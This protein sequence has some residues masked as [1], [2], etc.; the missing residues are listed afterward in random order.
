[1]RCWLLVVISLLPCRVAAATDVVVLPFVN[2]S[3]DQGLRW[4][5]E[6]FPE[7]L[8]ERLRWPRLNILGREER[9]LAYDRIGIPYTNVL[10]KASLVKVGQEL[11]ADVLVLGEYQVEERNLQ[12]TAS[13]L[14]LRRNWLSQEIKQVG[15]LEDLQAISGRLAWEILRLLESGFPLS[16]D[17]FVSRFRMI[18]NIAL[19]HY[20]RGIIETDQS[21]QVRYLRQADREHPNFGKAIFELGKIFHQMKDYPTSVLWLQKLM[22]LGGERSEA[23]FLMGLNYLYLKEYGKAAFEFERLGEAWPLNQVSNNLGIALSYGDDP[24][25]AR[26]AFERAVDAEADDP[27]SLFNLA[28]HH[29]RNGHFTSAV[30]HLRQALAR[31]EDDGE[32]H[33]LLS[34]CLT[35]IGRTTEGRSELARAMA[36]DARIKTWEDKR[37]MPDL[38]RVQTHFDEVGLRQLQ[39]QIQQAQDQRLSQVP[40]DQ[41]LASLLTEA[42]ELCDAGEYQLSEKKLS[43]AIRIA[44]ESVEA[45]MMMSKLLQ[46]EGN[47]ERA[48]AECKSALW[49]EESFE[50]RLLLSRLYLSANRRSEALAEAQQALLLDPGNAEARELVSRLNGQ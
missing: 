5:G 16:R 4:M 41:R 42:R 50:G 38:F 26:R 6:S 34:K 3:K 20:I 44:P 8:D 1:M 17:E 25:A 9:L 11:D 40:S 27:D 15:E 14:D 21:L 18:P 47:T 7:L 39:I 37:Q 10:S 45:R 30:P 46:A 22:R 36:L 28:Y 29:W 32:V 43:E 23:R 33:Y 31:N 48:I 49:L 13:L 2:Q 19:E 12:V 35:A 24:G